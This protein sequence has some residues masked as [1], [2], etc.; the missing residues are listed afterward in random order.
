MVLWCRAWSLEP[1]RALTKT[2]TQTEMVLLD[3]WNLEPGEPERGMRRMLVQ[4][5]SGTVLL[6]TCQ[7]ACLCLQLGAWRGGLEAWAES[8]RK[9]SL[10][11]F[12][13][14]FF[15]FSFFVFDFFCTIQNKCVGIFTK[16][17][18]NREHLWCNQ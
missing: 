12:F 1:G 6:S 2:E 13:F 8:T 4:R 15:C 14:S 11:F 10:L 16:P 3:C 17:Q 9:F 7:L 18:G 5:C